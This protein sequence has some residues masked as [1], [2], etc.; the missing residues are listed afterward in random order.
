VCFATHFPHPCSPP[1]RM[2]IALTVLATF[3]FSVSSYAL[4]PS[5]F[6]AIV[7]QKDSKMLLTCIPLFLAVLFVQVVHEAAHYLVAKLRNI[8][9]GRPTPLPSPQ[10]GTFGCITPI[11]S[12]PSSRAA[13]F[14]LSFS[15]PVSAILI[16]LLMMWFGVQITSRASEM[17]LST[18]P[19]VPV[20]LFKSS[21]LTSLLLSATAPKLMMLPLAQPIAIH[22]I[23]LAGF[24]GLISSSLNM[25][26]VFRL[27]GGRLIATLFGTRFAGVASASA[28]LFM[29]SLTISGTS[30]IALTWGL[31]IVFLQRRTE[32]PVRDDVTQVDDVRCA[33]WI[34]AMTVAIAALTP[35][36]GGPGFL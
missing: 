32:V 28:L 13:L 15:G 21:I 33:A 31:L 35:C 4:N 17:A 3:S 5:F 6:D 24:A 29:L 8:K 18:F 12:F 11:L 36:P 26:P 25:L 23:F 27:D 19:F 9:L 30:A 34:V 7:I 10:L 20:S 14:D 2:S 22:P 16:S 1:K